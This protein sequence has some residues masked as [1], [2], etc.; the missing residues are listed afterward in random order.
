MTHIALQPDPSALLSDLRSAGVTVEVR[1]DR[2]V[3]NA[4]ASVITEDQRQALR[5]NKPAIIR[6]LSAKSPFPPRSTP[7]ATNTTTTPSWDAKDRQAL[8][9][10][11]PGMMATV[12]LIAG[13]FG[14]LCVE[15]VESDG[16]TPPRLRA[17][18]VFRRSRRS[19]RPRSRALRDGWHERLSICTIDGGLDERDAEQI[20]A[21]E[22]EQ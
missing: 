22:V 13:V 15:A 1:G 16:N 9:K 21:M 11:R 12:D 14:S 7:T 3:V 5:E 20:A 17:A 2:L 4:P 6:L 8:A 18:A 10:L 19:D